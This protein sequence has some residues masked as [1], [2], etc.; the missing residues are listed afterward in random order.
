VKHAGRNSGREY[1]NPVSA[2]PFGDGFVIP[3]L[4]GIEWPE[5]ISLCELRHGA[6][7]INRDR[8]TQAS[9]SARRRPLSWATRCAREAIHR[10]L[11]A[12]RRR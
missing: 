11:H 5:I 7:A 2:Y 9:P 10:P 1:Q 4:Y 6:G 12:P 8:T 3:V